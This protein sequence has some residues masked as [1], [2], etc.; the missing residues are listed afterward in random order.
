MR[1][2]RRPVEDAMKENREDLI[3]LGGDLKSRIGERKTRN[4]EEETGDGKRKSK[5]KVKNAEGK[6]LMECIEENGWQVLNGNKQGA[7][8]GNEP[9]LAIAG[10]KQ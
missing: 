5:D 3:L 2:T 10:G 6:R 9:I 7:K 1:T 8:K 4:W